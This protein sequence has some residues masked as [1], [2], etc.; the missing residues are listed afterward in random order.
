MP[1][2]PV[3][4][5]HAELS[6]PPCHRATASPYHCVTAARRH[7][8]PSHFQ[9][10]EH[11][12]A[13]AASAAASVGTHSPVPPRAPPSPWGPPES[14]R[15]AGG[16]AAGEEWILFLLT[17]RRERE[18]RAVCTSGGALAPQPRCCSGR[19][20]WHELCQGS[21]RRQPTGQI[22]V[23][24][25]FSCFFFC[26]FFL[27]LCFL[28]RCRGGGKVLLGWGVGL[29]VC[30]LKSLTLFL[31]PFPRSFLRGWV[32][33][34]VVIIVS[35]RSPSSPQGW[36]WCSGTG[37]FL[38]GCLKQRRREAKG[39]H[40][41]GYPRYQDCQERR[42]RLPLAPCAMEPPG[43]LSGVSPTRPELSPRCPPARLPCCPPLLHRPVSPLCRCQGRLVPRHR[44]GEGDALQRR[45]RGEDPGG[46]PSATLLLSPPHPCPSPKF[47]AVQ[48][49]SCLV[50]AGNKT[51]GAAT[52]L[53]PS[54]PCH[55]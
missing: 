9:R 54:R 21:A 36:A 33:L 17:P 19:H 12:L 27:L 23:F 40:G 24:F 3:T 1:P 8:S 25:F 6:P 52:S 45:R 48:I 55:I 15:G 10:G 43:P 4:A 2:P 35:P 53:N 14:P 28:L 47:K 31:L 50:S 38:R 32:L 11:H 22:I 44:R 49:T 37:M 7:P 34:V 41:G 30:F 5:A 13:P 51:A 26:F 29:F 42:E 20:R 16:G 18:S 46:W 39:R